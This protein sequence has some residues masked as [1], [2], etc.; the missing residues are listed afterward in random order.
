[1]ATTDYELAAR[2]HA[3]Y[4][5]SLNSMQKLV[6]AMAKVYNTRGKPPILGHDRA[7]RALK[8][9]DATLRD[10]LL[11]M[12]LDRIVD[13]G[14]SAAQCRVALLELLVLFER[15]FPNWQDAYVFAEEY[16]A[17]SPASAEARIAALMNAGLDA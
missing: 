2:L 7:L 13:H 15:A 11:S 12:V 10:T 17:D 9:F 5:H 4:P 14:E 16:F 1:M 3:T 6:M 8:T